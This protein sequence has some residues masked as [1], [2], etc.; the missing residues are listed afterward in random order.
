MQ[1]SN[2]CQNCDKSDSAHQIVVVRIENLSCQHAA[3]AMCII[4]RLE[5]TYHLNVPNGVHMTP[6]VI[7]FF[8]LISTHPHSL[9]QICISSTYFNLHFGNMFGALKDLFLS[10]R[11]EFSSLAIQICS[12]ETKSLGTGGCCS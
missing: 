3:C 1:S 7:K 5:K 8:S 6:S 9:A 10:I 2:S 11:F 4:V 12:W